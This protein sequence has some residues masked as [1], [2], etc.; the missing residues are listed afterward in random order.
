ML[1]ASSIPHFLLR[2]IVILISETLY[3]ILL[4]FLWYHHHS[5]IVVLSRKAEIPISTN[6]IVSWSL[7]NDLTTL[8]ERLTDL[9]LYVFK[10][11]CSHHAPESSKHSYHYDYDHSDRLNCEKSWPRNH[12]LTH[13]C[14]HTIPIFIFLVFYKK[15]RYCLTLENRIPQLHFR[16]DIHVVNRKPDHSHRIGSRYD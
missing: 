12:M 13:V 8:P 2:L 14:F 9:P 5:G 10:D 11:H 16:T 4:D 15:K 3:Y 7:E 6:K 1:R